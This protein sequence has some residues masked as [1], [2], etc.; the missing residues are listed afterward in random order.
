MDGGSTQG[1]AAVLR[2]RRCPC[3]DVQVAANGYL[4][5]PEP[6]PASLLASLKTLPK[7]RE[8]DLAYTNVTDAGLDQLKSLKSLR[9]L[10]LK[11]TRVTEP[12]V[13]RLRR[14]CPEL[15]IEYAPGRG[16]VKVET[17]D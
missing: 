2:C 9:T 13:E 5:T 17:V 7:L 6:G 14:E 4:A 15:S 16:Y 8:L 11:G 12:A 1:R 10:D 3:C